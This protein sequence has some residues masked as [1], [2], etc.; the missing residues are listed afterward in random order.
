M[1]KGK[2]FEDASGYVSGN[3][4]TLRD[5]DKNGIDGLNL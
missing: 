5:L 4:G 2:T 3:R 1:T